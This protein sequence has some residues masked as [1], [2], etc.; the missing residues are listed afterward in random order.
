[1][2]NYDACVIF[3]HCWPPF[4]C[5]FSKGIKNGRLPLDGIVL[6]QSCYIVNKCCS[7]CLI[8][9]NCVVAKM[10]FTSSF[11]SLIIICNLHFLCCSQK[12]P[13][14]NL[15]ALALLHCCKRWSLHHLLFWHGTITKMV[16]MPSFCS[17]ILRNSHFLTCWLCILS[18]LHCFP[19]WWLHHLSLSKATQKGIRRCWLEKKKWI[20]MLLCCV[21]IIKNGENIII[22]WCHFF[23]LFCRIHTC[24]QVETNTKQSHQFTFEQQLNPDKKI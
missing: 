19:K 16:F 23:F 2:A 11:G 20:E 13:S 10:I 24:I 15:L 17:I 6:C 4:L 22:W 3:C 21:I 18:S 14:S 5:L 12:C 9:W 1:M 8:N 7:C